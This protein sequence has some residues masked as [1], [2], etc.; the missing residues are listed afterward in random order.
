MN[1]GVPVRTFLSFQVI[2]GVVIIAPFQLLLELT[3]V[4]TN[5]VLGL[6]PLTKRLSSETPCSRLGDVYPVCLLD[7]FLKS[8]L[9]CRIL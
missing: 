7:T 9:E 3:H 2:S 6:L 4:S 5:F 1:P 8:C